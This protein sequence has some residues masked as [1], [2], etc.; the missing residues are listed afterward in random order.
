M[1]HCVRQSTRKEKYTKLVLII[2]MV[3]Y[4]IDTSF[5]LISLPVNG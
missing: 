2:Y 5:L 4:S 3:V 1:S